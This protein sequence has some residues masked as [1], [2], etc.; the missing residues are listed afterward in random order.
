[1][2]TLLLSI[3]INP[4]WAILIFGSEKRQLCQFF[5]ILKTE[6][7]LFLKLKIC[8]QTA[9]KVFF[10]CDQMCLTEVTYMRRKYLE[11]NT[12]FLDHT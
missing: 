12:F 11:I 10:M 3:N 5:Q 9:M 8:I 7:R 1:M 6:N 2:P 4:T